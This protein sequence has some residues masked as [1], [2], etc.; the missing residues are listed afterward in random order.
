VIE[1]KGLLVGLLRK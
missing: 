1:E